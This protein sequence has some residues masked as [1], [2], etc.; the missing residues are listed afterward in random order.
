MDKIVE[1]SVLLVGGGPFGLTLAIELGR[2]GIDVV[3]IDSRPS[4]AVNPQ[5]NATQARTMEH[6]RRLGFADEVRN[7][8]LPPD[9]PTDIAYF[10]RYCHEELARF[11][12]PPS[13]AAAALARTA[14]D[15]VSAA[16]LPHRVSQKFV[17]QVLRRHAEAVASLNY[18]KRLLSFVDHSDYVQA[19]IEDLDGEPLTTVRAKYLIGGDGA[20]STTRRQLGIRLAGETGVT[21]DFFGGRMVAAHIR[22][23]GFYD[24]VHH[25]RAWMYWAFNRERR[26]WLAAVNGIDEFAFHTQLKAGEEGCRIDAARARDL[27][28]QTMGIDVDIELISVDTWVAGHTLVAERF[29][30]GHVYIGGDAAHLF[31]PAGGLG[32]NTAVEDA[33]NLG[34][35]LALAVT[36]RAGP[37]LLPSYEFERQKIGIRNTG[38]ARQLAESIGNFVPDE[39]IEE[40]GL[41]GDAARAR[42][43]A[44]LANHARREFNIPGVTFGGRYD[45]SPVIVAD[46]TLPPEDAAD[47]YVASASPG[48]RLPHLW[49]ADGHS[50]F[51]ALGIEWT[52]LATSPDSKL[53]NDFITL[54]DDLGVDLKVIHLRD[55]RAEALYGS[56]HLLVRPDQIVAWRRSPATESA[57]EVFG[58]VLGFAGKTPTGSASRAHEKPK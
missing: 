17:E 53:E 47:R 57:A 50:V 34:W 55:E 35:K 14:P 20:R 28:I 6:F 25:D 36:G 38:F 3:V 43:G 49:I 48:G 21:R 11:R 44:F 26:S 52:L 40:P 13:N 56:S 10:T 8:G 54:A 19:T 37:E 51:D 15:A 32:Y 45:G 22:V 1:T 29:G 46:G 30:Q 7:M 31:T 39:A 12:R 4:T 58:R 24:V 9:Y 23:P 16:E 42:A 27:F 41:R 2:R 18:R 5:A 33:V